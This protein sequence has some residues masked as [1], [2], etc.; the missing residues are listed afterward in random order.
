V[1]HSHHGQGSRFAD[2]EAFNQ[3]LELILCGG[4]KELSMAEKSVNNVSLEVRSLFHRAVDAIERG[5]YDYAITLLEKVLER[6]PTFFDAHKALRAAQLA[7]AKSRP[8]FLKKLFRGATVLGKAQISIKKNP[9]EAI[10]LAEK[11]LTEDPQN[12]QAHKIIAEAALEA[13]M[14]QT[15]ILSLEYVWK[16]N[17]TDR[18]VGLK[19][20]DALAKVGRWQEAESIL[21]GLQRVYSDDL[22]IAQKLRDFSARVA[23]EEKGYGTFGKEG[24]SFRA[25]LKDQHEAIVLEKEQQISKAPDAAEKLIQEYEKRLQ[26]E[27]DNLRLIRTLGDLYAEKKDFD[28][29]LQYYQR[30]R[31]LEAGVDPALDKLI[32][33]ITA[34]K[35]DQMIAALD[36][37]SPDYEVQRA[38]L[39]Q[40]KQN[41]LL[42]ECKRRAERYPT[43]LQIRFELGTLYYQ[44]GKLNEAIQEFQKAQA[45]PHRRVQALY[46]L[47]CCFAAKGIYDL[48]IRAFQNAIK[49]KQVFDD[50]KKEIIYALGCALEK[51]GRKEEAIEQFKLIY[52]QDIGFKDVASKIDEYY[53][54]R[55]N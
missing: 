41:Y 14:P 18:D 46:Y 15:A 34:R 39:I 26:A 35:Y 50:E 47:G 12:L 40:E 36:Q 37:G 31:A 38:Q 23:M 30:L 29:A 2:V 54:S 17:P 53:G 22:E 6:E 28:R 19:L 5:N 1:A 45:H 10:L 49:E 25:A 13:D 51:M 32:A 42:E 3:R 52:E 20:A 24:S 21:N 55:S 33:D 4:K 43:D 8:G 27:P 44:A 16:L 11:V 48:A 7:R 9:L